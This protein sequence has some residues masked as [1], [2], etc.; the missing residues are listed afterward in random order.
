MIRRDGIVLLI[1][2]HHIIL[3]ELVNTAFLMQGLSKWQ[4]FVVYYRELCECAMSFGENGCMCSLHE[5]RVI[6]PNVLAETCRDHK[7]ACD[8]DYCRQRVQYSLED[9]MGFLLVLDLRIVE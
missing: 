2:C 1:L 4:R 5:R 9:A 6:G 7:R 8:L 3:N